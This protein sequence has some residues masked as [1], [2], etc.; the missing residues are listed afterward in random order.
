MY[1]DFV[2]LMAD[3]FV[4]TWFLNDENPYIVC[5]CML[6][7]DIFAAMHFLRDN[8]TIVCILMLIMDLVVATL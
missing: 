8:C 6:I 3:L 1:S 2:R 5:V 4:D 7:A